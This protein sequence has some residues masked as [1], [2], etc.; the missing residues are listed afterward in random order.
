MPSIISAVDKGSEKSE[1]SDN[2]FD[3]SVQLN[4]EDY[5]NYVFDSLEEI[6]IEMIEQ[7]LDLKKSRG[8]S[9]SLKC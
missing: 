1:N 3:E 4:V 5:E 8:K 7:C 6:L 2:I 9:N